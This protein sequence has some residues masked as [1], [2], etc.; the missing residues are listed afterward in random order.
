MKTF[1]ENLRH[2]LVGQLGEVTLLDARQAE[3]YRGE[4]EPIDPVA[5]H[6]P[7]ARSAPLEEN[8]A[9]DGRFR[10]PA[11][12]ADHYLALGA[13]DAEVVAYCG[14]GVTACHDILAMCIAGLPEPALYPG[15]WSDWCLAGLPIA[16]GSDPGLA[17]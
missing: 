1:S 5:G 8:L 12:L 10:P 6:I 11:A 14:S 7:T 17:P 3:R 16:T 13:A 4:E 2:A 9:A 15:S